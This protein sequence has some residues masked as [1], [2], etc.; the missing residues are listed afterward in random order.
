MTPRN[1]QF[2][3]RLARSEQ[4]L[5]AAERLRY[6]VFIEELGGRGDLVDH[7]AQLERDAH[8]AFCDHLIL[9]DEDRDPTAL[10]HV[11]GVYRLLGDAAATRAG[12]FY[13]A[14]EYDLGPLL[15]SGRKLLELGRSCVAA[16]Y[17]GGDAMFQLW[18]GLAN[19]VAEGGYE[20][21]FGVA[22]FHG[23]RIDALAEPLSLLYHRH[24]AP[25]HL[26]VRVHAAEAQRMDLLPMDAIDRARALRATPALIK[27]Y[28]RLGGYVG[29]GAFIDRDFNTTDVCLILDTARLTDRQRGRYAARRVT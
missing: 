21:L 22:S 17:R 15:Q 3:L 19:Y 26:R 20:I 23:T 24:L 25:E 7:E 4:D 6:R 28:V 29:D 9:V 10:N 13:S 16:D 2:S 5:R 18:T 11:V 14:G 8:D 1:P 12:G 27:A